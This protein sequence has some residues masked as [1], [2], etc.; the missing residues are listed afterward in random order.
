MFDLYLHHGRHDPAQDMANWGFDGPRISGVTGTHWTYGTWQIVFSSAAAAKAA[1]EETG[2]NIGNDDNMLEMPVH[3]DLAVATGKDE[4]RCYYGDWGLM[5][6]HPSRWR[7]ADAP[8]VEKARPSIVQYDG[9][10]AHIAALKDAEA[11]VSGFEGDE[12]QQGI[13]GP[14][15]LLARLRK[16]LRGAAAQSLPDDDGECETCAQAIET[17]SAPCDECGHMDGED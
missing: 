15:G 2:W 14:D 10:Q 17:R 11:F 16:T 4:V 9:Y 1:Q 7:M 8:A 12:V 5:L 13:D 3:E 6:S